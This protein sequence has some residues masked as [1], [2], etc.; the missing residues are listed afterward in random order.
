MNLSQAS[1]NLFKLIL[2]IFLRRIQGLAW[3]FP[4]VAFWFLNFRI[5]LHW[6]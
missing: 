6:D 3:N 2:W 1:F 5:C 4:H